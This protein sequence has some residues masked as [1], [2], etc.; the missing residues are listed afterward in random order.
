MIPCLFI[1]REVVVSN[2]LAPS[3][4]GLKLA[5]Q[6]P[7]AR[8][9][10]NLPEPESRAPEPEPITPSPPTESDPVTSSPP[11]T[12][13]RSRR[14]RIFPKTDKCPACQS[15]MEAP[16]IRH[17][18]ACKRKRGLLLTQTPFHPALEPQSSVPR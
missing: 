10:P 14:L 17:S 4:G 11:H 5:R 12:T 2:V 16:G 8:H 3:S 18:A 1:R 7:L 6:G 9:T 13:E 15:G